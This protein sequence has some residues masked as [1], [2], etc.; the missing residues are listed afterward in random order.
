MCCVVNDNIGIL[1]TQKN[2]LYIRFQE[3]NLLFNKVIIKL[4][5]QN[6]VFVNILNILI[7]HYPILLSFES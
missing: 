1:H 5:N 2:V 7:T 6:K 3:D 4:P